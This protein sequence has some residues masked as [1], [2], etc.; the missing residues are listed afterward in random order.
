MGACIQHPSSPSPPGSARGS[1]RTGLLTHTLCRGLRLAS[2]VF[3]HPLKRISQVTSATPNKWR[4]KRM[5]HEG[6]VR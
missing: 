6:E 5:G 1:R 2:K 3:L 4:R